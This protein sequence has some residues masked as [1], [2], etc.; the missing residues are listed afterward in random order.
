MRYLEAESTYI[1]GNFTTG[2]TV[3]ITVYKLSD[4]SKVIDAA[5]CAEI[6]TT[7]RFK[8][9]FSQAV[10]TKTEYL[11]IMTNSIEEQQGK[12]ILGGYPDGIKDQTDKMNFTG[13]DIKAT[14]DGEKVALSDATETQID[15]IETDAKLI[16]GI[17]FPEVKKLEFAAGESSAGASIIHDGHLYVVIDS[18]PG[19]VVKVALHDFRKISTL[20][21]NAGENTPWGEACRVGDFLYIACESGQLIKVDLNSFTEV[22]SIALSVASLTST[23]SDDNGGY[24]YVINYDS[25]SVVI[26]IDIGTFT[27]V[28]SLI[29]ASGENVAYNMIRVGSKLYVGCYTSPGKI[30]K[31]DLNTFTEEVTLTLSTNNNEIC[32]LIGNSNHIYVGL[33]TGIGRIVKVSLDTFTESKTLIFNS[34]ESGPWA[35]CIDD[36]FLYCATDDVP[37]PLI[38]VGLD[39]FT[40]LFLRFAETNCNGTC[41]NFHIFGNFLIQTYTTSPSKILATPLSIWQYTNKIQ[42]KLPTNN[43]MGSSVKT[44]KDDEIDAIKTET[45]KIQPE[46]IG[47]KDEYKATGFATSSDV[48]TT[49]TTR[50]VYQ[51][52]KVSWSTEEKEKLIKKINKIESK[53]Q[54]LDTKELETYILKFK[55]S[56]LELLKLANTKI[57]K[58]IEEIKTSNIKEKSLNIKALSFIKNDINELKSEVN[59]IDI[60]SKVEDINIQL[61][62]IFKVLSKT[63]SN[64]ELEELVNEF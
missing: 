50:P 23:V 17:G 35:F 60:D 26:K 8:Y 31:V 4:N 55:K 29:L 19:K 61:E 6:S 44:D 18:S 37:S 52:V 11:W 46:I 1:L 63:L 14:L 24:L 12:I 54:K 3:T 32:G 15:D 40:R 59:K 30:V 38:V 45:D 36:E 7:G 58:S 16:K 49:V 57:F 10:A 20:T 33:D 25:P 39:S 13:D 62:N 2:D 21:F 43:I 47:K 48:K 64:K 42:G 5:A 51:T 53:L 27:E 22:D 41:R 34:G 9:S 56:L 28:D